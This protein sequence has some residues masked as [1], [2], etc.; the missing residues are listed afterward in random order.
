ML[1]WR[2]PRRLNIC[3]FYDPVIPLLSSASQEI[4]SEIPKGLYTFKCAHHDTVRTR[5]TGGVLKVYHQD[6]CDRMGYL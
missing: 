5:G 1:E 4:L 2:C 6:E 3:M